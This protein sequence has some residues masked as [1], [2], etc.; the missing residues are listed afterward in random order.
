MPRH[1]ETKKKHFSF[2]SSLAAPAAVVPEQQPKIGHMV[3]K[4]DKFEVTTGNANRWLR[5]PGARI[6]GVYVKGEGGQVVLKKHAEVLVE[7]P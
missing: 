4:G 2:L 7:V 3:V 6:I 5:E 1:E